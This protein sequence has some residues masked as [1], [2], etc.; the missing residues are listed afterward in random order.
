MADRYQLVINCE[1]QRLDEHGRYTGDR[2]SVNDRMEIPAG[3]FAEICDV[4]GRFHQLSET[5]RRAR[6]TG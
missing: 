1:I 6:V 4:L 5:V 2:L 3:N